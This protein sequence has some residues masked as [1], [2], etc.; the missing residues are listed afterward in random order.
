[1]FD[2]AVT[3][4]RRN[5]DPVKLVLLP[6]SA[7]PEAQICI[8]A[9]PSTSRP[10]RYY[11]SQSS[12]LYELQK[13]AAPKTAC[14]SWLL[15][16]KTS[17]RSDSIRCALQ[18]S[19]VDQKTTQV[20]KHSVKPHAVSDVEDMNKGSFAGLLGHT[21]QEPGLTIAT[22][23]DVLFL[24]LP[25]LHFQTSKSSKPLF[26]SLDDLFEAASDYSMHLKYLL[27]Q[28]TLRQTIEA[29]IAAICDSVDAGGEKMYRLNMDKLALELVAK[30]RRM[31]SAGLPLSLEAK[32]V[33]KALEMPMISFKREA[34]SISSISTQNVSCTDSPLATTVMT[35][36]N[37]ATGESSESEVSDQTNV[38][39][40]DQQ[41]PPEVPN[42]F[43][44]D[45]LRLRTALNF[46]ISSYLPTSLTFTM[47]TI[48]GSPSGP[49]DFKP[50]DEHL[51]YLANLRLKALVSSPLSNISRKRSMVEENDEA[52]E[53]K[54]QKRRKKEEE[55][56][57]RKIGLT[58][59]IKDL[60]K[61]DVTG[62]K[63]MSDFF[64]KKPA[65]AK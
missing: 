27:G 52:A 15:G 53:A 10:S 60:K 50:L 26:L 43:L 35:Q 23:V 59:G 57:R 54:A 41:P 51:A 32:L 39:I 36:V 42:D 22:P 8:L 18:S 11:W 56:K 21:I 49:I 45:L 30:A 64:G 37:V 9:H 46:I 63:K 14:R 47:Q 61:V 12:G 65:Q 6:Q 34:S 58:K 62:M 3:D 20:V 25:S 24:A 40:S 16:P 7:G 38:N 28:E 17:I 44:R 1:M 29:R 5:Q 48:L 19:S 33:D 55:E 13:V 2:E 31:S 4:T